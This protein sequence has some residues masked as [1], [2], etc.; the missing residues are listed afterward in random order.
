MMNRIEEIKRQLAAAEQN[1]K[2]ASH[3]YWR[4]AEL[5]WEEVTAGTS[6]R[7]LA[8]EIGKSHTHVRYM[9]NCWDMVGRKI[10][11]DLPNFNTVYN[12]AEVRGDHDPDGGEDGE[13]EG[14][15]RRKGHE[16]D[17]YSAH[18]LVMQASNS[19]DALARNR[20]FWALLTDDDIA[21]LRELQPVI[22]ALIRD[23]GR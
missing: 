5:V 4:A 8:T 11:G 12:S 23:I 3:S 14:S 21:L 16:P 19:I 1:E 17:D 13:R 9:F 2:K 22:R 7:S 10:E 18:G 6:R 15:H 20:A